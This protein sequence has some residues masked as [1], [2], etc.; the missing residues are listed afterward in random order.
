ML[1]RFCKTLLVSFLLAAACLASCPEMAGYWSSTSGSQINICYPGN[2]DSFTLVMTY[3]G[4]RS[5]F[6]AYWMGGFRHQFQYHNG[7]VT[8]YGVYD[9]QQDVI[10]LQDENGKTYTWYRN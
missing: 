3:N 8:L 2:P 5:E 9:P 1:L 10:S 7:R 4:K 6:T